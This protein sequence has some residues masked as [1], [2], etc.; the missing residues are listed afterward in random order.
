MLW[1]HEHN[2]NFFDIPKLTYPEINLLVETH[3]RRMKQQERNQKR[4]SRKR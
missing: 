3:N 1:L 4:A 2:Y